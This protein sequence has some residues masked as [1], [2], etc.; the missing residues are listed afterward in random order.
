MRNHAAQ[1][2]VTTCI[3]NRI[4]EPCDCHED[5]YNEFENPLEIKADEEDIAKS[6]LQRLG[7]DVQT[8]SLFSELKITKKALIDSI[9]ADCGGMY[10]MAQLKLDR[11]IRR[12]RKLA[13]QN[14]LKGDSSTPLELATED[15]KKISVWREGRRGIREQHP[16]RRDLALRTLSWILHLKEPLLIREFAQALS[17]D[18]EPAPPFIINDVEIRVE[19]SVAKRGGVVDAIL[20]EDVATHFAWHGDLGGAAWES[21]TP[22]TE[23]CEGLISFNKDGKVI[24]SDSCTPDPSTDDLKELVPDPHLRI[25][26]ACLILLCRP[27]CLASDVLDRVGNEK[28]MKELQWPVPFKWYAKQY[29]VS[30]Y[31]A[32]NDEALDDLVVKYFRA[33]CRHPARWIEERRRVWQ[34]KSYVVVEHD[35]TPLLKAARLGLNRVLAKLLSRDG[36]DIHAESWKRESASSV[37]VAAGH[38]S[39]VQLLYKHGALLVDYRDN[40]GNTLLHMAASRDDDIMVA[41]LIWCGINANTKS[42]GHRPNLPIQTAAESNSARALD[43]LLDHGADLADGVMQSAAGSG[44]VETV[45]ILIKRGFQLSAL[46][47]LG[48]PPLHAAVKSGSRQLVKYM[49]A[50]G[51]DIFERDYRRTSAIHIAAQEGHLD[52]VE[53][54]LRHGADPFIM[55]D[56]ANHVCDGTTA[57]KEAMRGKHHEILNF[58]SSPAQ[59]DSEPDRLEHD[60]SRS[61]CKAY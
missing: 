25:A 32:C 42:A 55:D 52:I 8:E 43:M 1:T 9:V 44:G 36:Y 16:V 33:I 5:I 22:L 58:V 37:A 29:W 6:L 11:E 31:D 61:S 54:L 30:H 34:P 35:E 27:E 2:F 39:T 20:D 50:N 49:I 57:F 45:K 12:L 46:T 40:Y 23:I 3:H 17:I 15:E 47:G 24:L 18:A 59:W 21:A 60:A 7:G 38:T 4:P 53:L 13:D 56:G 10:L 28:E 14:E 48:D 51:A 19:G 41:L 26:G